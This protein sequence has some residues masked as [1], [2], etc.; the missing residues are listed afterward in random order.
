M[1]FIRGVKKKLNLL[2]RFGTHY[3]ITKVK[4]NMQRRHL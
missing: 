1:Y 4:K 3:K 2:E